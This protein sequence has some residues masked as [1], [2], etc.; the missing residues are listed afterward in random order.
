[1]RTGLVWL[2]V[3]AAAW[4]GAP[5]ARACSCA[6]PPPGDLPTTLREAHDRARFI[7]RARLLSG[8]GRDARGKTVVEVLESFKGPLQPG[9]RLELPTTPMSPCGLSLESGPGREYL[10]YTSAQLPTEIHLCSRTREMN[11]DDA[12]MTWLRTGRPPAMPVALQREV[13]TCAP[14]PSGKA[15]DP[16][17]DPKRRTYSWTAPEVLPEK[18]CSWASPDA[19][20]CELGSTTRP[21]AADAP[22]APVLIC[23]SAAQPGVTQYTCRVEAAP[24]PVSEPLQAPG[25]GPKKPTPRGR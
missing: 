12:E 8:G 5:D 22:R 17:E 6:P 15:P 11:G 10:V 14:D 7:Y 2:G 13:M 25:R 19:P 4:L 1:M 18:V 16:C 23:P 20:V 24:R 9:A 21:L 3:M